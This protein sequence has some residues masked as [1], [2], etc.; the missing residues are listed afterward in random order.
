MQRMG[1]V[2]CWGG[3]AL[4][5]P[6]SAVTDR[7]RLCSSRPLR[8]VGPR[9][10]QRGL[11]SCPAETAVAFARLCSTAATLDATWS[12]TLSIDDALTRIRVLEAGFI[13]Q[14][15]AKLI[16]RVTPSVLPAR[17]ADFVRAFQGGQ[18]AVQ[19]AIIHRITTL[20]HSATM[21]AVAGAG[22]LA[23]PDLARLR[24]LRAKGSSRW[25]QVRPT[26]KALSM[27][28]PQ[29]QTAV[30]L[31]LGM[32]RPSHGDAAAC[33]HRDAA[34]RDGWHALVCTTRSGPAINERHHA[35]VRILADA[36][37]RLNATARIEPHQLCEHDDSRPDIQLDL[38]DCT[39]L[40]LSMTRSEPDISTPRLL[41][42]QHSTHRSSALICLHSFG[43]PL[44]LPAQPPSSS[45]CLASPHSLPAFAHSSPSPSPSLSVS[46]ATAAATGPETAA[47]LP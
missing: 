44:P 39:L 40:G 43:H 22:A 9:C 12:L 6:H 16:A 42:I 18:L 17:A 5:P 34:D 11:P 24:A 29:W 47:F 3:S 15:P 4:S 25:L 20:S 27:T 32:S 21:T 33:E 38:A 30:Q 37:R 31:R 46:A 13:S 10:I 1:A 28:D 2:Q 19:S 26:D 35:V 8:L 23:V 36:A 7:G 41:V 14:C 45:S